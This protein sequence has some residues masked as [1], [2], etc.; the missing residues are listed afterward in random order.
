VHETKQCNPLRDGKKTQKA[1][2]V[3]GAIFTFLAIAYSTTR[4]ATQSRA[5]VGK[6]RKARIQLP[7]DDTQHSELGV[8][9]TQPGRTDSPRYQALL[10]A[11]EAGYVQTK[12][13]CHA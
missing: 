5:L 9:N 8:V 3:L 12:I 13:F 6:G 2:L 10:A 11:V 1:V 4:A 7:E